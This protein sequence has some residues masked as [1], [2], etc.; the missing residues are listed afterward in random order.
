MQLIE[1]AVPAGWVCGDDRPRD[2]WRSQHAIL[3]IGQF[4]NSIRLGNLAYGVLAPPARSIAVGSATLIV[5]RL[6]FVLPSEIHTLES[7]L[8][9]A[10]APESDDSIHVPFCEVQ[11]ILRAVRN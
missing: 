7:L 1:V 2:A 11:S 10:I 4:S 6:W 8:P 5:N 9:E 3:G